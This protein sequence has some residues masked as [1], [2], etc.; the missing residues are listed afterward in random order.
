VSL[1]VAIIYYCTRPALQRNIFQTAL[2][3]RDGASKQATAR[4]QKWKSDLA[5]P[6]GAKGAANAV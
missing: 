2:R 5:P 3:A 6:S 1:L 4:Q